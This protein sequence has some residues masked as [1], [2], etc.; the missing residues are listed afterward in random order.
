MFWSSL[1]FPL[2]FTWGV[3]FFWSHFFFLFFFFGGAWGQFSG[4]NFLERQFFGDHFFGGVGWGQFFG[5]RFYLR[6]FS[7]HLITHFT[8]LLMLIFYFLKDLLKKCWKD[9]KDNFFK[10]LKS[11]DRKTRSG[12]EASTLPKCK[13]LPQM[14]FLENS[15]L[16]RPVTSHVIDTSQS[17]SVEVPSIQRS[18]RS[19]SSLSSTRNESVKRG[20]T[21]NVINESKWSKLSKSSLDTTDQALLELLRKEDKDH[22]EI[23]DVDFSF[24]HSIMSILQ[25]LL[26]KKNQ[27]AKMKIWSCFDF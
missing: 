23:P 12:A 9:I 7:G 25:L 22:M 27:L 14:L 8:F 4:G 13:L 21:T 11:R 24:T 17:I 5:G 26:A 3:I 20:D 19:S 18:N 1:L 6:H 15:I 10:C 2:H 16:N